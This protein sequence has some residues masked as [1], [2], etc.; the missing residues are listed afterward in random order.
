MAQ[1][2]GQCLTEKAYGRFSLAQG[3]Q[4]LGGFS[5][6]SNVLKL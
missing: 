6:P 5:V 2:K 1:P 3:G 4:R